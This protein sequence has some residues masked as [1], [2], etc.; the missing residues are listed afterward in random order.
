MFLW[1][2]W[3]QNVFSFQSPASVSFLQ[4]NHAVA[5][6]FSLLQ[7]SDINL[8]YGD[9]FCPFLVQVKKEWEEAEHQAVNL[10]KAERQTLIQVGVEGPKEKSYWFLAFI[11]SIN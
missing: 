5:V 3:W 4:H 10:P 6:R 1:T 2:S 7:K 8:C 9:M 11:L